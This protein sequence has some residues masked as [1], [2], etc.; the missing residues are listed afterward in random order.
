MSPHHRARAEHGSMAV[1]VVVLAPVM[2]A[3]ILSV[4]GLGRYVEARGQ[5]NDIAYAA[6]RAASLETDPRAAEQ[7]GRQAA[8]SAVAERGKSCAR[9]EV[10]FAGSDFTLGGQVRAE[11]TCIADLGDVTGFGIPGS[12]TFTS[13]AVVPIEQHRRPQ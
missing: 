13:D 4:V 7:A 8:Y 3:M 11:V 1:E 9:L 6:A 5:V 2:V 12:K 10:S